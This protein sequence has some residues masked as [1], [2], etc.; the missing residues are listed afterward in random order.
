MNSKSHYRSGH[1]L[2]ELMVVIAI[3]A[4]I[5][6]LLLPAVQQVRSAAARM[7]S[8]NQLRQIGLATQT[9]IANHD[10]DI[11]TIRA[12][13]RHFLPAVS[14]YYLIFDLSFFPGVPFDPAYRGLIYQNPADPSFAAFPS[15]EGNC[16]FVAN[17]QIFADGGN[18]SRSILDGTSNTVAWTETYARC[19]NMTRPTNPAAFYEV[20]TSQPC[21]RVD[22]RIIGPDRRPAFA[23]E[24]CGNVIPQTTGS[25]PV[26]TAR[27][28]SPYQTIRTFQ[29][30][31]KPADCDPSVPN[32]AFAN[33]LMVSMM[34]GSV[35]TLR[36]SIGET[37]YWALV[38][39]AAGDMPGDW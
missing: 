35:R 25:P 15:Q 23:D 5:V 38:T 16:S 28:Q 32:S 27:F 30:A 9:Y 3:L 31:P 29:V 20:S 33:G 4:I 10:G 2:I 21:F 6:S 14:I 12:G 22:G 19:G 11:P 7:K 26:T 34:D 37:T 18:I 17:S 36:G 8:S 1:S 39:P 13:H 24:C